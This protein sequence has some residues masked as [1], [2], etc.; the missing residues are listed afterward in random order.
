M[1]KRHKMHKG[2]IIFHLAVPLMMV[3]VIGAIGVCAVILS[4]DILKIV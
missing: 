4:L 3:A 1:K 2:E